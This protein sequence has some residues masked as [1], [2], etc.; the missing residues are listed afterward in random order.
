MKLFSQEFTEDLQRLLECHYET[1]DTN[2][3]VYPCKNSEEVW[4]SRVFYKNRDCYTRQE[5]PEL[6]DDIGQLITEVST[7]QLNHYGNKRFYDKRDSTDVCIYDKTHSYSKYMYIPLFKYGSTGG[8][9][10][11][12]TKVVTN[13]LTADIRIQ[14]DV[15]SVQ[16]PFASLLSEQDA[17]N[18]VRTKYEIP[19]DFEFVTELHSPNIFFTLD[20]SRIPSESK[21]SDT[22]LA[23]HYREYGKDIPFKKVLAS[24]ISDGEVISSESFDEIFTEHYQSDSDLM[25]VLRFLC[26]MALSD[27]PS[28]DHAKFDFEYKPFIENYITCTASLSSADKLLLRKVADLF[29]Q[30]SFRENMCKAYNNYFDADS[31]YYSFDFSGG[32]YYPTRSERLVYWKDY[33]KYTNRRLLSNEYEY[34]KQVIGNY[35]PKKKRNPIF[36][37]LLRLVD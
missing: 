12:L 28:D 14:G 16:I 31:P 30:N 34:Q 29:S 9:L 18:Y 1:T 5:Q 27:R 15:K 24:P 19:Q 35:G 26:W 36:E 3:T 22:V 10:F 20:Y 37:S 33:V 8:Q 7:R 32:G 11:S 6:I 13:S 4:I 23:A 21:N 17:R 2:V 25:D